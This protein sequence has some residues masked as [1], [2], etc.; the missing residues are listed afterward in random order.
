MAETEIVAFDLEGTLTAGV[1]WEG[2]RDYLQAHGEGAKFQRFFRKNLLKVVA[3]RVGI[4]RDERAFK[5]GWILDVMRLFAGYTP[6]QFAEAAAWVVERTFW[7][8]RRDVVVEE[9]EVHK[10][11]G[12]SVIIVSGMFEPILQ[13]FA[14]KLQVKSI[15]TPLEVVNGRLTGE[16]VGQLNVGK[17][18][19]A[20]L[21]NVPG[22]L[23]AAYGD[24]VRDIPMLQMAE[25]AVAVHPDK[26]LRETAV[27]NGWRI[28][29]N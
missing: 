17:A 29:T 10:E 12:R 18:K 21:Q 24:T 3:F 11:N 5:E 27:Q 28:L 16:I 19:V 26:V 14:A 8:N 13:Q 23:V 6:A 20:Q 22:R 15:G 4:L 9:L 25:T 1:A 7:P 2:M